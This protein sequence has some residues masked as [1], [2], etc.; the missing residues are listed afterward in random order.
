M[1][2]WKDYRKFFWLVTTQVT[3]IMCGYESTFD[4]D[5][6]LGSNQ[7]GSNRLKTSPAQNLD[8]LLTSLGS[9]TCEINKHALLCKY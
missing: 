4:Y 1:L 7:S 6:L 8:Y 5:S 9:L 3:N 2:I